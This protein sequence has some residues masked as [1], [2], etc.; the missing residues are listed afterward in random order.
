MASRPDT[1]K[2][3]DRAAKASS[4]GK[5]KKALESYL[6]HDLM[7]REKMGFSVP[8]AKWFR[9]PL[10]ER[11]KV[12]LLGP[13]LADIGLFNRPFL[14]TMFEQHQSG[15]RDYSAPLWSLLMFEAFQ[16]QVLGWR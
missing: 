13:V 1:R 15:I 16:R 14:E 9:G 4:K 11:L 10:R 5:H 7:Y 2:L 6:P 3:K 12:A 8:L